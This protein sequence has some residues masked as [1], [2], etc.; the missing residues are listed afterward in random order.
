MANIEELKKMADAEG[1]EL[2]EED[3]DAVA[4]GYYTYEE[5]K[6]MTRDEK[7]AAREASYAMKAA[8]STEYCKY[9]DRGEGQ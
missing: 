9:L 4:G 5:W 8:G 1:V 2:S 6:A 3:L 7:I